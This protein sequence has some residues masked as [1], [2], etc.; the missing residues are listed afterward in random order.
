M[1]TNKLTNSQFFRLQD[2]FREKQKEYKKLIS[3][4]PKKPEKVKPSLFKKIKQF[5]GFN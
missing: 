3:E 1:N 5:F 4:L 2:S